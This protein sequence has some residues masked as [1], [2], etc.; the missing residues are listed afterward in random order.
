MPQL[1]AARTRRGRHLLLVDMYG[2]FTSDANDETWLMGDNLHSHQAGYDE[3]A[4]TWYAAVT[5]YLR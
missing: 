1:V 5:L 3:L 2:A 4:A